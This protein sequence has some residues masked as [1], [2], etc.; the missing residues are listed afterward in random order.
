MRLDLHNAWH[1]NKLVR[2]WTIEDGRRK[3]GAHVKILDY[4]GEG[5]Y[6]IEVYST[7]KQLIYHENDF[8]R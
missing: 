6:E 4:A 8:M 5:F 2:V 7:G 3:L 1:T